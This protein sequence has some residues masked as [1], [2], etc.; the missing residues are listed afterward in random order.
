MM[1]TKKNEELVREEGRRGEGRSLGNENG[2]RKMNAVLGIYERPKNRA[3]KR[4]RQRKVERV[5]PS[6]T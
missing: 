3:P 1:M 2:I 4:D 6:L 5:G